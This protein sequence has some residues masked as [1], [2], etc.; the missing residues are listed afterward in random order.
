MNIDAEILNKI[1]AN[2]IQQCIK[3]II[4]YDQAGFIPG[5]QGFFSIC[6]SINVVH[7]INKLEDKNH[8]TIS[9]DAEK[10]FDKIQHPFM[11]KSLQKAGIEEIYLNIIK[12]ICDETIGNILLNGEKLKA[13]LLKSGTRQGYQLSPL[14]FNIVLEVLATAIREEKEIKGIQIVKEVNPIK[15]TV[16][17][18]RKL[19]QI[20][21][22]LY[23]NTKKP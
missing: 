11:I 12:A 10:A 8:M 9:I 5:M 18:F 17:F 1:L 23:G 7:H 20:I 14:L 22:N 2:G 6:I 15:L 21:H 16:V 3:K 4:H 19:E 13:F